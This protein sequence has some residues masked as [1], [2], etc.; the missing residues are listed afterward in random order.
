MLCLVFFTLGTANFADVCTNAAYLH[1]LFA[2]QAH[3]LRR[4]ITD[5]GTFHVQLNAAGHHFY[6]FF[7]RTGGSTMVADSGAP[8]AHFNTRLILVIISCHKF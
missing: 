6:I 5:G 3:E 1:C 7:L 2:S 4:C 8:E